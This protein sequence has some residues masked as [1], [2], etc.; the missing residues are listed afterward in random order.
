VGL[1]ERFLLQGEE[2][3]VDELDVLD[4]VINHIVKL[5]SLSPKLALQLGKTKVQA[6]TTYRCPS[7]SI[8]NRI[9]NPA[10]EDDRYD[11]F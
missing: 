6:A 1:T 11:L 7:P 9:P 4:I 5:E 3:G 8:T 10:L 2:D